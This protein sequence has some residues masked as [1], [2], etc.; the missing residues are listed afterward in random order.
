MSPKQLCSSKKL[1]LPA[2]RQPSQA[3][4]NAHATYSQLTLEART[5][6][7]WAI[8]E[9][10]T[11]CSMAVRKAK[12][13]R[14]HMIQEAEDTCSKAIS[15]VK[16]HRVLQAE[17]LPREHGSIMWDLEGQVIQ[18]ES[19]SWANF[20]STCQVILYNSPPEL[21]SILA[22]SYHLLL[23]QTPPSP[24]LTPPWRTSPM[25]EQP[26]TA[27]LP[28]LAPKQSHR[29]RR[30]HPS[31]DPVESMLLS[32]TTQKATLRGPPAPRGKRPLSGSKHSSQ[33]ML[34]CLAK[35]LTW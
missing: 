1:K 11:T 9:A 17:L 12:T 16:V 2:L 35:T 25:E 5:N 8:L 29:P 18:E 31:P 21:K 15:E 3:T 6:C 30:W 33:V 7:S 14:G 20:L 34:R 24:T 27:A 32:G 23:G 13:T 26:T 10:K 28:K 19:R 4:L 22:T